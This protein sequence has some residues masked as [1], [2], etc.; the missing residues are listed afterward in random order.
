MSGGDEPKIMLSVLQKIFGRD[1][2]AGRLGVARQLQIFF[3]DV[4]G[5]ATNFYVRTVRFVGPRQRTRPFSI[6][7]ATTHTL[8]CFD[9]VSSKIPD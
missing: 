4:L 7:V 2:I 9:Q 1:R 5:C 3:G 6:W 8:C